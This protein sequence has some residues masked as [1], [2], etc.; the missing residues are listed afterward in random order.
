MNSKN[1][2]KEQGVNKQT[3]LFESNKTSGTNKN[4]VRTITFPQNINVLR[5]MDYTYILLI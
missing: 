2:S 5:F 3:L 4:Q 1:T